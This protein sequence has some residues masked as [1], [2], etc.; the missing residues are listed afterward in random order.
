ML[1][2]PSVE[3]YGR[4]ATVGPYFLVDSMPDKV[5]YMKVEIPQSVRRPYYNFPTA[6]TMATLNDGDMFKYS[7]SAK[8]WLQESSS[9]QKRRKPQ[10]ETVKADPPKTEETKKDEPPKPDPPKDDDEESA[11]IETA[12]DDPDQRDIESKAAP[13][14][15]G[16]V[17]IRATK[18]FKFEDG[19]PYQ[20]G[21]AFNF[22]MAT[23]LKRYAYGAYLKGV[24]AASHGGQ[25]VLFPKKNG[26]KRESKPEHVLLIRRAFF[27][28]Y[29]KVDPV[30][31]ASVPPISQEEYKETVS[32]DVAKTKPGAVPDGDILFIPAKRLSPLGAS[33][34]VPITL[35]SFTRESASAP[36]AA[37][38]MMFYHNMINNQEV[39]RANR[40][41]LAR[42]NSLLQALGIQQYN[43]YQQ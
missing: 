43:K 10:N 21:L 16:Y 12:D 24:V 35:C 20:D 38:S 14:K 27:A 26:S 31:S 25:A 40:Q 42:E 23:G 22:M 8:E 11:P 18:A 34:T 33:I 3:S 41:G 1:K 2:A 4:D 36:T 39:E 15:P 7:A 32:K 13:V 29:S 17:R 28:P 6:T 19:K 5:P 9:G 30:V 37:M